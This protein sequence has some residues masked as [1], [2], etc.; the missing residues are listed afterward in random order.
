MKFGVW[1]DFRNP[2][3]WARPYDVVYRENLDQIIW[4]ERA[5]FESVWVSEHHATDDGYLPAIFPMLAAIAENTARIRLG[6]SVLLAPFYHPIRFAEDAAVVDQLSRGRLEIG[7]GLGYRATEFSALG[8]RT[9]ERASRLD[10][11]VEVARKA[12]SG[13]PFSHSGRHWRFENLTVTPAPFQRP[14]PPLW[15]GGG[16]PAS[17]SRAARLGCNFFP[18]SGTPRDIIDRYRMELAANHHDPR[19]FE[20]AVNPYLY[21]TDDPELGWREVGPHFVYQYNRYREWAAEGG[22][23]MA[24]TIAVASDLPRRR[25]TVGTP[26]DVIAAIEEIRSRTGCERLIFWA[27]PPGLPIELSNQ[28]LE[29]FAAKVMPAFSKAS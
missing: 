8:V 2:P 28:S 25:Y 17:A 13:E 18:D 12:W 16:H 4:A 20:V 10:E 21:V 22:G 11:L 6:T 23:Q 24:A 5:G 1:Y 26:E 3:Q 9:T 27:R 19:R 15:I 14:A 7:L 29:L